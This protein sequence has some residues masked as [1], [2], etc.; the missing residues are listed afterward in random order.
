VS[1]I[2]CA[3]FF[4]L[5]T[6]TT[7]PDF[8]QKKPFGNLSKDQSALV[9]IIYNFPEGIFRARHFGFWGW[10]GWRKK[11]NEIRLLSSIDGFGDE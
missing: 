5:Y 2:E 10:W 3:V 6:F 7:K 8:T 4:F 1:L 11:T 9:E